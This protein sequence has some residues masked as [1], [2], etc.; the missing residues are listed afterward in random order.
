MKKSYLMI[1]AVAALMA[2][3]SDND[4]FKE[5]VDNENVLIGFETFHEKSTRAAVSAK[6]DLTTDN[7]GFG[8]FGYNHTDNRA[9]AE[10]S[11]SMST[12]GTTR[13]FNNVKV[14]YQDGA[15]T[16]GFT[17]AV[18][19][20]WDKYKFYTF[21]AYAPWN[22]TA[23]TLTE[24]TGKFVRTDVKSL[25]STNN[26]S[27]VTVGSESRVK[28]VEAN[29]TAVTDYLIATCVTGQKYNGTNQSEKSYTG[30]EKTVGFTFSH[31][32]SKLNV[33]VKAKDEASGHKYLG[34]KDIQVTSLNI[35]N[36]PSTSADLTY[37]QTAA[38]GVAGT[39]STTNYETTLTIIGS[40]NA[41]TAG[42]LYILD[43]GADGATITAPT[44]YIDQAFHYWV[45]PNTP[46]GTGHDKY[47]L[48]IN[49][50]IN[51]VDGTSDPFT[52]TIDLSA[53]TANFK[54]MAQ[55]NIYNITVTIA[56][57]Q[58]YFDVDAI[59]GWAT[60][61]NNTNVELN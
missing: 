20:Y 1:A 55:N 54:T 35:E 31:I 57:D 38:D 29:E 33:T 4:N 22:E 46:T 14:W 49:Y 37:T 32:L 60:P 59:E 17:Y 50:T 12:T 24:G 21:F 9:V 53:A 15:D 26:A 5:A 23:V 40:T 56:L 8:V 39:F 6:T 25:Q 2:S 41:L 19:K 11:I 36:L 7:G 48:N 16:D 51:Y 61:E 47:K 27:S 45:A 3:C 10:G 42:P 43:G 13:V 58:I 44:T 30:K 52:R 28:Y 34:V 18:P